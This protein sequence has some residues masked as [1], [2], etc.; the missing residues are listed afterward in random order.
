MSSVYAINKGVNRP[1]AFRGLTAQW[2]WWLGGGLLGLLLLFAVLYILGVDV[3]VCSALIGLLGG[4]LFW[5]VYRMNRRFGE[6]GLMKWRARR[7]IPGAVRRKGYYSP[8]K[9]R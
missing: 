7:Y 2:I 5:W 1:V 9:V 8:Q 4:L 6:F 3:L